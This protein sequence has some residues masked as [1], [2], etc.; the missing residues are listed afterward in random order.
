L[1]ERRLQLGRAVV[2]KQ[3]TRCELSNCPSLGA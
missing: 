1:E 3:N 2:K